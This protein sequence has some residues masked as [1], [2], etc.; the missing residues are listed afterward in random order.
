[1]SQVELLTS[2]ISLPTDAAEMHRRL[3][4]LIHGMQFA[5][6]NHNFPMARRYSNAERIL[7]EQL[8]KIETA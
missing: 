8:R 7:R 6:A 1:L 5:I 3:K 4:R 2:E